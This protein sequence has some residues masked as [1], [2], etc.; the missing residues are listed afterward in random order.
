MKITISTHNS[1]SPQLMRAVKILRMSAPSLVQF[2]SQ[3]NNPCLLAYGL[4]PP[5]LEESETIRDRLHAES[6]ATPAPEQMRPLLEWLIECVDDDGFLAL[7]ETL[8]A[9]AAEIDTA[10]AHL[11]ALAPTGV[12]ARTAA[13]R[14]L[15]LL[16]QTEALPVRQQAENLIKNYWQ[17]LQR[18][19]WDKLPPRGRDAALA[20]IENLPPVDIASAAATPSLPDVMFVK[21]GGLW[22]ARAASGLA[23]RASRQKNKN[24][25]LSEW[26][27]AGEITAAVN[28]RR[29][30]VLA[31]AQYAADCQSAFFT[32][33]STALRALPLKEAA[34]ELAISLPLLS[35]I[36]H[37]KRSIFAGGE[38][39]LK[40][41]YGANTGSTVVQH[42]IQEMIANENSRRPLSDEQLRHLL[43]Q[44]GMLLARR[45]VAKHR[46]TAGF[47]AAAHRKRING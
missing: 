41:L 8:P 35:H 12:A 46:A 34:L 31:A 37:D 23:I 25:S 29:R 47:T 3:H 9:P 16:Q 1:F 39:P 36:I 11:Q 30:W 24:A 6:A 20:L 28:S 26:R 22:H 38:F 10:I 4:P 13:E 40:Y 44:Q 14:L 19:R 32:Q 27:I 18:K 43:Q 42:K 7:P 15:L 17:W 45:T 21:S 5:R 33:G 2:L